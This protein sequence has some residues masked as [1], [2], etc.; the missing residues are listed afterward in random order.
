MPRSFSFLNP[1]YEPPNAMAMR[2]FGWQNMT[3]RE[4]AEQISFQQQLLYFLEY[5]LDN[6]VHSDPLQPDRR[7]MPLGLSLRAGVVKAYALAAASIIEGALSE[8]GS[9]RG[10]DAE[11]LHRKPLGGVL[12]YFSQHMPHEIAEITDDLQ[13]V[14][15]YRD[16]VHLGRAAQNAETS[17]WENVL[18]NERNI[19]DAVD[20]VISHLSNKFRI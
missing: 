19:R 6:L 7:P 3:N 11:M 13:V 2:V 10:H 18:A 16:Y 9:L 5:Q 12:T 17:Y 20:R 15:R 8:L 1:N 4:V 14:K